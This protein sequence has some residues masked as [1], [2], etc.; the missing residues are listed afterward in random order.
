MET[1]AY[2]QRIAI[3]FLRTA[4]CIYYINFLKCRKLSVIKC[5]KSKLWTKR[6]F[7]RKT[8][9]LSSLQEVRICV[10]NFIKPDQSVL[11]IGRC[12]CC[13]FSKWTPIK[14]STPSWWVGQH[15][16][17]QKSS[18]DT[19]NNTL[20]GNAFL[21]AFAFWGT[22]PNNFLRSRY[23]ESLTVYKIL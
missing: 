5:F 6:I 16:L 13:H 3:P 21:G 11:L 19:F 7:P 20:L 9:S 2:G 15:Y 4:T 22:W 17:F 10:L 23:F 1:H 12:W 8:V 14:G 18:Y